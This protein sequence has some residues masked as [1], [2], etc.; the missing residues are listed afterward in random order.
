M[1][2]L[3]LLALF[4]ALLGACT[5]QVVETEEPVE[6]VAAVESPT[7]PPTVSPRP[8]EEATPT[9]QL[10]ADGLDA[11]DTLPSIALA[12]LADV[13]TNDL[14]VRSLPGIS[15]ASVIHPTPLQ[16]GQELFVLDG[17]V[18]ADGHAWYHVV[19]LGSELID[20]TP[21]QEP[22]P[23]IGWVAAGTPA[24][25]WIGPWSGECPAAELQAMWRQRPFVLLACFGD[26]QLTLEGMHEGCSYVVPGFTEPLWLNSESCELLPFDVPSDAFALGRITFHFHQQTDTPHVSTG[27][28]EPV[29][30][31][32]H[33]DDPAARTCVE[34]TL[35]GE[36][37]TPPDLVILR[38]RSR[39]VTTDVQAIAGP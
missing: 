24:D 3:S 12:R 25:P 16:D 22:L 32:G 21:P 20:D 5:G 7:A 29:R 26:R 30:V 1:Q 2:R 13:I 17:P 8:T 35:P 34:H 27:R 36:E 23:L 38:C 15:D 4:V 39:F 14:V 18:V 31:V 28:Q 37:P 9:A 10:E 6:T 19:P 33:F 11:P